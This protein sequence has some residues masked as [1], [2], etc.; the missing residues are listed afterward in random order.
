MP[1]RRCAA[2]PSA[3]LFASWEDDTARQWDPLCRYVVN[4]WFA[5][6][7]TVIGYEEIMSEANFALNRAIRKYDA[8]LILLRTG[9]PIRFNTYAIGGIKQHLRWFV[10]DFKNRVE[11]MPTVS[12]GVSDDDETG[13][14]DVADTLAETMHAELDAA[15]EARE[16]LDRLLTCLHRYGVAHPQMALDYLGGFGKGRFA[17]RRNRRDLARR[18]R[19]TPAEVNAE[20]ELIL[21]L[22]ELEEWPKEC[23]TRAR[24]KS[25]VRRPKRSNAKSTGSTTDPHGV[26]L[27]S[28]C[29]RRS[30]VP[31][32]ATLFDESRER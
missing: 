3:D 4:R 32:S 11:R 9:R 14:V 13:L 10:A 24:K 31:Q 20:L 23:I 8:N 2:A 19:L 26:E 29:R 22:L 1:R 16:R 21:E 12:L 6:I 27:V 17:R 15:C 18:Y 25:P 7:A 28:R 5:D 30:S